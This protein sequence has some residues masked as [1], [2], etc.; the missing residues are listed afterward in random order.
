MSRLGDLE[1]TVELD[2][3]KERSESAVPYWGERIESVRLRSSSA[4]VRGGLS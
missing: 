1:Q 4:Q 2:L 3:T